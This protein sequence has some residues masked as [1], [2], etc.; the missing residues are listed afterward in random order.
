MSF[1]GSAGSLYQ[2]N[3]NGSVFG[4][5]AQDPTPCMSPGSLDSSNRQSPGLQSSP[6]GFPTPVRPGSGSGSQEFDPFFSH[7]SQGRDQTLLHL[8]FVP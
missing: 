2:E 7:P 1:S 3:G 5:G 6:P 8:S 4:S